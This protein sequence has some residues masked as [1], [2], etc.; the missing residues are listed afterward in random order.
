M[1]VAAF[2]LTV[3]STIGVTPFGGSAC[4]NS[5]IQGTRERT[6]GL[7]KTGGAFLVSVVNYRHNLGRPGRWQPAS[8]R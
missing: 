8:C 6:F 3:M 2:I 4:R 5:Q 1:N 7:S